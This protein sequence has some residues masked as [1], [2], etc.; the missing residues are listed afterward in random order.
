MDVG[1]L[2]CCATAGGCAFAATYVATSSGSTARSRAQDVRDPLE[3][4]MAAMRSF[5]PYRRMERHAAIVRG[6]SECLRQMPVML[7]VV[8]L[9][10]SAG[11]S[12]DSA[13]ELYCQRYDNS[14]SRS[15][16]AAMMSWRLG[17]ESRDEA[18]EGMARRMGVSSLERFA[19]VVS[20]AL[21]FGSPLAA[22]LEQQAQAIRE[23]QRAQMEEVI[24]Q[25]PVK[26][27]IPLGTLIVPAMLLAIL[28]PLLGASLGVG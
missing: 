16:G 15:L 4:L 8:T 22:T 17:T 14:L 5:A 6:R 27:L 2:G 26:M 13:L 20:Q 21:A 3:G 1:L 11:L 12:F 23:E 28:G 7:D 19:G 25:I 10:L 24:E 9:G 18:L